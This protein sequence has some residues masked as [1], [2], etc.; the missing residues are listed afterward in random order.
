MG[1]LRRFRFVLALVASG[2]V[3]AA[4]LVHAAAASES[5]LQSLLAAEQ[6]RYAAFGQQWSQFLL[7]S[8]E[9]AD[10]RERLIAAI[11]I[12]EGG[13]T[14]RVES[15]AS[16]FGLPTLEQLARAAAVRDA[17]RAGTRDPATLALAAATCRTTPYG[18]CDRRALFER[19]TVADPADAAAWLAL[20]GEIAATDLARAQ[21]L[22]ERAVGAPSFSDRVWEDTLRALYGAFRREHLDGAGDIALMWAMGTASASIDSGGLGFASRQ[23]SEAEVRSA[24]RRADCRRLAEKIGQSA[25]TQLTLRYAQSI[26][27][28]A[29]VDA[30]VLAGWK[31]DIDMNTQVAARLPPAAFAQTR[32]AIQQWGDDLVSVGEIEAQR[33]LMRRP[34]PEIERWPALKAAFCAVLGRVSQALALRLAGINE[35]GRD[36]DPMSVLLARAHQ[37]QGKRPPPLSAAQAAS[38]REGL[39]RSRDPTLLSL[40]AIECRSA[41]SGCDAAAVARRWTEVE[42]DNAAAWLFLA[43]MQLEARDV[44]GARAS[45]LR[46]SGQPRY[47]GHAHARLRAAQDR[48]RAVVPDARAG[49]TFDLAYTIAR[50]GL[51]F[52]ESAVERFCVPD[53]DPEMR[54]ACGAQ[55]RRIY[56]DAD[57]VRE[58]E[59]ALRAWRGIGDVEAARR[60]LATQR[61][62]IWARAL[63]FGD[64]GWQ[65]PVRNDG[66]LDEAAAQPIAEAVLAY[67]EL[68]AVR[69]LF[70][71]QQP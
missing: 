21:R 27:I 67:G 39:Q 54:A 46:A 53:A 6:K 65:H 32:T 38:L 1:V 19:W 14:P 66:S 34:P 64:F 18:N 50:P 58:M 7:R 24:G 47:R 35:L 26:G 44:V 42:T 69:A 11:R 22:F 41:D 57:T 3:V 15:A 12:L 56:D 51:V 25:R 2:V 70:D 9:A 52:G 5:E 37:A 68:G 16:G 13:S 33:R 20:A 71:R 55:A 30:K 59:L 48:L 63:G 45:T 29:G 23:C 8:L 49:E 60:T 40:A 17:V 4:A 10:E 28:Y 43:A 62:A 31:A 61:L 36:G